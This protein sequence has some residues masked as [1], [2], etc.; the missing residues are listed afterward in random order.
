MST[1]YEAPHFVFPLTVVNRDGEAYTRA[2]FC[3]R[4]IN[5]INR[6]KEGFVVSILC[7]CSIFISYLQIGEKV[8]STGSCT[9]NTL[10]RMLSE[11]V[12]VDR[13]CSQITTSFSQIPGLITLKGT[14]FETIST[15]S[16]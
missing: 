11:E 8:H 10:G 5:T 6:V 3:M 13:Y 15:D 9:R 12:L 16:D 1:N 2:A 4:K 7:S 14:V